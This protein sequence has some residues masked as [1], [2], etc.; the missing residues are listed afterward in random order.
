MLHGLA[1][2]LQAIVGLGLLN[3]WLIRHRSVTA[4]RGGDAKSLKE[5]FAIYGLPSAVF[6]I[7][8]A[9]KILSGTLLLVGLVYQPVVIPAAAV[10]AVLMAAALAMHLKVGDRPSKSVPATLMLIMSVAIC[11]IAYA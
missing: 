2:I 4:Y 3:V 6:Y 10:V 11:A 8:G 5:E 7:V 1:F 9:L